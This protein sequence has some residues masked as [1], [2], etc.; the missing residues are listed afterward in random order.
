MECS[1]VSNATEMRTKMSIDWPLELVICSVI[2]LDTC[3]LDG[4][5]GKKACLKWGQEGMG[6]EDVQTA[7]VGNDF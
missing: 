3:G 6:S 1:S 7:N 4:E 5:V 2:N